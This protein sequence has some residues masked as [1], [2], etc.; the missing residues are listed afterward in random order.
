MKRLRFFLRIRGNCEGRDVPLVLN[1]TN[2][3][4]TKMEKPYRANRRIEISWIR[5]GPVLDECARRKNAIFN[6]ILESIR[7]YCRRPK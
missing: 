1:P 7:P 2:S 3:L 6:I 5:R 4:I